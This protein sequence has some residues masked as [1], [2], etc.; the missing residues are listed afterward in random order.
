LGALAACAVNFSPALTLPVIDDERTSNNLML[1]GH[2]R[3]STRFELPE[4]GADKFDLLRNS[5][6]KLSKPLHQLLGNPFEIQRDVRSECQH[7]SLARP[8]A[9]RPGDPPLPPGFEEGI[10]AWRLLL[11]IDS[12]DAEDGLG[13]LWGDVGTLYLCIKHDDLEHENFEHCWLMLQTT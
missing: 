1:Y 7:C 13:I 11:Q 4:S 2:G 8:Y 9:P 3:Q 6:R 10:K 12:D 5:I